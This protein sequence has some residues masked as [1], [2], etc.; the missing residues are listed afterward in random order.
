M[1]ITVNMVNLSWFGPSS[2]EKFHLLMSPLPPIHIVLYLP[3][4]QKEKQTCY[5]DFSYDVCRP[6]LHEASF[7]VVLGTQEQYSC[8]FPFHPAKELSSVQ[9]IQNA[10]VT[11]LLLSE[12][13]CL[14]PDHLMESQCLFHLITVPE[15]KSIDAGNSDTPSESGK[16][17]L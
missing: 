13:S 17:F 3:I 14:I 11:S 8:T 5:W 16:H 12:Q 15:Y 4:S 2:L 1:V 7:C 9:F 10:P 6:Q